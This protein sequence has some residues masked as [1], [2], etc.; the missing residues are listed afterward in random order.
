MERR[1]LLTSSGLQSE[2]YKKLIAILGREKMRL[3][4]IPNACTNWR[5]SK[6]IKVVQERFATAHR[7]Q[8]VDL[9]ETQGRHLWRSLQDKNVLYVCGG[10]V[11]H[12]LDLAK[13]SGFINQVNRF[14]SSGGVYIG[15]SAGSM[16]AGPTIE[17]AT[18]YPDFNEEELTAG[19]F[20]GFG[21]IRTVI[22]PHFEEDMRD[23]LS[24]FAHRT[25]YPIIGLPDKQS[26]YIQNGYP[27]FLGSS[28]GIFID[29]TYSLSNQPPHSFFHR[30]QGQIPSYQ[31]IAV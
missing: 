9:E 24:Y 20:G 6:L 30:Y 28:R 18:I 31:K 29:G 26:V 25:H 3:G 7:L 23:A 14:V 16:I 12:L 4:V 8:V 2:D 19:D 5:N 10:N 15:A 27:T 17:L 22:A 11:F 13:R 21:L 1:L